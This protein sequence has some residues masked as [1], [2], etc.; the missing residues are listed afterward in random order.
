MNFLSCHGP[1]GVD[2]VALLT[3][4]GKDRRHMKNQQNKH[5]WQE[6]TKDNK[7]F[8][9]NSEEKQSEGHTGWEPRLEGTRSS[10]CCLHAAERASDNITQIHPVHRL[11]IHSSVQPVRKR[12][13]HEETSWL[14]LTR[15]G[16]RRVYWRGTRRQLLVS[17]HQPYLSL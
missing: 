6:V 15:L 5:K 17:I 11:S 3:H 2:Q 14:Q 7:A 1:L 16:H 9:S 13:R 8:I 12:R 4:R 10:V